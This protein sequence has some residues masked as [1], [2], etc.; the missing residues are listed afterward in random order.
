MAWIGCVLALRAVLAE[1][2]DRTV[3]ERRL[4]PAQRRRIETV[5][6]ERT[7]LEILDHDIA[8]LRDGADQLLALDGRDV[9]GDGS[10][11]A[12]DREEIAALPGGVA[13]AIPKKRRTPGARIVAS[14]R[15]LDLDDVGAEVGEHLRRPRRRHDAPEVE[16]ANV[17]Q[18]TRAWMR[19][20]SHRRSPS[21]WPTGAPQT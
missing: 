10:L 19:R 16:H 21:L 12:I 6:R 18:R 1:A 4:Q 13:L 2:G 14:A 7:D 11:A 9:D 20:L 5:L 3:D 8:L 15:P 17:R